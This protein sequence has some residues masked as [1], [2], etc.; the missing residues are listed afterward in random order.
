MRGFS[1]PEIY[2]RFRDGG[3]ENVAF[4]IDVATSSLNGT[5]Y[6]EYTGITRMEDVQFSIRI[7]RDSDRDEVIELWHRCD[8]YR[9]WND[10]V[11]DIEG[12][13]SVQPELFFV[14]TVD[15]KIVATVMAGFDGH[16]GWIY[17]LGVL[18]EYQRMGFGKKIMRKAEEELKKLGCWKIN[19]QVRTSNREAPEFYKKIGYRRDDV[20]SMGKRIDSD[21]E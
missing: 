6:E 21:G 10:P 3:R 8:L 15:E 9:T 2:H 12:K 19:V 4:R 5:D 1:R 11:R 20:I 7:Y 16:R 18:P 13:M 17:Y 14:G